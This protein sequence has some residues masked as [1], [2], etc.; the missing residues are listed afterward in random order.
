MHPFIIKIFFIST[1]DMLLGKIKVVSYEPLKLL[2]GLGQYLYGYPNI[3]AKAFLIR[4][5]FSTTQQTLRFMND[6]AASTGSKLT[7]FENNE[8]Q[9]P[10]LTSK[11]KEV[12]PLLCRGI[13]YKKIGRM[14]HISLDTVRTHVKHI[15]RK[16]KVKNWLQCRVKSI[17]RGWFKEPGKNG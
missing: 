12:L 15:Y 6:M 1:S 4:V 7:V 8:K 17:R 16:L 13:K 10:L 2:G 9:C 5:N 3:A 11:E 14:L